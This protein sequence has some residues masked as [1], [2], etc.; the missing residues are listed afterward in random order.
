M[1]FDITGYTYDASR[2]LNKNQ[3]RGAVTTNADTTKLNTQYS[4]VPYDVSFELNV[5]TSNS[6]DGLQIIEQI[7]PYFQ[8]DYTVTMIES[9]TMDTKRDIPFILESVDYSDSYA[10]DLTTTR[11]I[12]YTLNFT[13]KIYLYGPISTSA[14]IKKVSVDL[15]DATSDKGPSRSE[16]V[17]VTPNPTSADK[18]DTYTYTTTLDF[19]DDG[20]N[21]DEET[22][23][24]E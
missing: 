4:P 17:T 1:A 22:G 3:K 20:L 18:D 8:P 9:R 21:Y 15:Y 5:F 10:G 2:K 14:I 13:A 11:R 24:D 16:R 19:F 7:L 23:N 6:D 12:E